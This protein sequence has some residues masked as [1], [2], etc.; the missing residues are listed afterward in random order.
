MK[1]KFE[2]TIY[3]IFQTNI[4]RLITSLALAAISLFIANWVDWMV[5]VALGFFLIFPLPWFFVSMWAMV[6]YSIKDYK[7]NK[8]VKKL[9]HDFND[10]VAIMKA[11]GYEEN[12]NQLG[13]KYERNYK[14]LGDIKKYRSPSEFNN[15]CSKKG[16][17]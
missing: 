4:G 16:L 15:E 5:W 8:I 14:I 1:K 10:W 2:D 12:W 11:E 17:Y 7:H 3:F 13:Y 9:W 6:H